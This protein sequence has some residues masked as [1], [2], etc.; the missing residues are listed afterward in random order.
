MT[1]WKYKDLQ[2]WIKNGCNQKECKNVTILY[3]DYF[4]CNNLTSL[5][6]NLPSS[7][8]TIICSGINNKI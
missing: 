5:P 2:K 3:L 4:D 7:L 6:D 8:E 1:E